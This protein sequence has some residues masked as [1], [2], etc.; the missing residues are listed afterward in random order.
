MFSFG[1]GLA[2]TMY[3]IRVNSDPSF[4]RSRLDIE[5]RLK[6]R[7]KVSTDEYDQLMALRQQNY[8]KKAYTTNVKRKNFFTG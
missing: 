6:S 7:V 8:G 3:L 5:N 4:M 1:S 2:S